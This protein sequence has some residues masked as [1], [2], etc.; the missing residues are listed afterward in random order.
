MDST[1]MSSEDMLIQQC[2]SNCQDCHRICLET[3]AH[4]LEMGGSHAN[5]AHIRLLLD[6]AQVCLLSADFMTRASSFHPQACD[7]CAAV[8]T[9]CAE[10]CEQ[11]ADDD[12][13]MQTCAEMCRICADSCHEMAAMN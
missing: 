9:A 11:L 10:S 2:I 5:S 6:C 12:E 1:S 3:V 4:C 7:L 8:C 13:W